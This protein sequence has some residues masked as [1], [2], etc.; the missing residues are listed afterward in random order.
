MLIRRGTALD[1]TSSMQCT[2]ALILGH[3]Q[4]TPCERDDVCEEHLARRTRRP[5]R[6]CQRGLSRQRCCC[7][8]STATCLATPK[9]FSPPSALSPL[10]PLSPLSTMAA[11][12]LSPLNCTHS[13][14][15]HHACEITTRSS[16]APAGGISAS[17]RGWRGRQGL[18][19]NRFA[20]F[21]LLPDENAASA[22]A[23]SCG[24][25]A[26]G[27]RHVVDAARPRNASDSFARQQE[28][29]CLQLLAYRRTS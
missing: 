6:Q 26:A 23:H 13:S 2:A 21:R 10:S 4:L 24:P 3:R 5:D 1:S 20:F 25:R 7:P 9:P 17:P 15:H 22:D 11:A 16:T 19:E 27:W 8:C 14:R 12:P 28:L 18:C 29:R